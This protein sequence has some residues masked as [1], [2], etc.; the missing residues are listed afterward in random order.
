MAMILDPL[1]QAL[2]GWPL[3]LKV[4][5]LVV[6]SAPLGVALGSPFPLGLTLFRGK[7]SHFL[8]WAWSLNGSFSVV[9]TPLA[10]LLAVSAGYKLVLF[11]SLF[12]YIIVYLA[13]PAAEGPQPRQ[14]KSQPEEKSCVNCS[15]LPRLPRCCP[16]SL[17]SA[18][19]DAG[20]PAWN[21]GRSSRPSGRRPQPEYLRQ[22]LQAASGKPPEVAPR[23]SKNT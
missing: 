22:D 15:L 23:L 2:L 12:L 18:A 8:P 17:A 19:T 14:L 5:V 20:A 16:V 6:L 10:N 11:V 4:A 1:L 3:P 13:F 7:N 21:Y 9:A